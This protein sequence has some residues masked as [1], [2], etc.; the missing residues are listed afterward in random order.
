[1]RPCRPYGTRVFIHDYPAMNRWAKLFRAYG[2]SVQPSESNRSGETS[3][4]GPALAKSQKTAWVARSS[5]LLAGAGPSRPP[6]GAGH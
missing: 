6:G 2:A 3:T 5:P 4:N 1:M